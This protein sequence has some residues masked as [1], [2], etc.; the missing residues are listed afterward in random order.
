MNKITATVALLAIVRVNRKKIDHQDTTSH[1]YIYIHNFYLTLIY[2]Y[3]YILSADPMLRTS[4]I[5]I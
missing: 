4:T 2:I 3:T 5:N 1:S